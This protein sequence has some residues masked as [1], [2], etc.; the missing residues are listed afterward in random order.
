MERN[1]HERLISL[2]ALALLNHLPP[3]LA[4]GVV[5]QL[6]ELG[7]MAA[8]DGDT[9]V[10]TAARELASLLNAATKSRM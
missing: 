9:T 4:L 3:E 8:Q 1:E 5:N 2:F 10:G 7:Q 6:D